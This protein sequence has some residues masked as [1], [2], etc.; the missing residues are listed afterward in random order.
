MTVQKATESGSNDVAQDSAEN[1]DKE[2]NS[3]QSSIGGDDGDRDQQSS[4][5]AVGIESNVQID[6]A[7][8][9]LASAVDMVGPTISSR[10][11]ALSKNA[12][13]VLRRSPRSHS[14]SL[15]QGL[16]ATPS[17]GGNFFGAVGRGGTGTHSNV[18]S[19][20]M[21]QSRSIQQQMRL[22][23]VPHSAQVARGGLS[24][25]N[26]SN[27]FV[28]PSAPNKAFSYDDLATLAK[29]HTANSRTNRSCGAPTNPFPSSQPQIPSAHDQSSE[30]QAS[31]LV[32]A[33]EK[34]SNSMPPTSPNGDNFEASQPRASK[35]KE[36]TTN[37]NINNDNHNNSQDDDTPSEKS[38][39]SASQT[40]LNAHIRTRQSQI[41]TTAQEQSKAS[42][43]SSRKSD[44][45]H[46][47]RPLRGRLQSAKSK[48]APEPKKKPEKSKRR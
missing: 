43:S 26:T 33:R 38:N 1:Q 2:Q 13:Q 3:D 18:S 25:S 44:Q 47:Q 5:N 6:T 22:P 27:A 42:D 34:A 36:T 37:S 35:P 14:G 8:E 29:Q 40:N 11:P 45:S 31:M 16:S 41:T 28:H 17:V 4:N 10:V 23:S 19:S 15:P 39:D 48:S 7:Q 30:S 21:G 12:E 9:L 46:L 20:N 32:T 24:T